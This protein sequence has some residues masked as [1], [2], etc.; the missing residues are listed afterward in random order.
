MVRMALIGCGAAGKS[1]LQEM[2]KLSEI[3]VVAVSDIRKEALD[4]VRQKF[5]I[6][7]TYIDYKEMMQ[8]EELDA[9]SIVTPT[10]THP[11]VIM[12]AA[13][14]GL[15]VMCEKPLSLSVREGEAA[16]EAMRRADRVLAVTYTYRFVPDTRRMK[17][18]IDS[19]L[20]GDIL[21]IRYLRY[22]GR[23]EKPPEGSEQ[24]RRYDW[25]FSPEGLGLVYDCGIHGFDLL[26]W[27]AGSEVASVWAS[28]EYHMGYDYPD[29]ATAIFRYEN[30][31]K[32]LF[33]YGEVA[34]YVTDTG[35]LLFKIIVTGRQGTAV[36]HYAGQRVE[37]GWRTTISTYTKAGR[38]QEMF[39]TYTKA[40][41]LQYQ[42]FAES[43]RSGHLQGY[44]G[45]AE[46][47]VEATR[48]G[49]E[50]LRQCDERST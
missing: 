10:S 36:W 30:G 35:G 24:R 1:H 28:G 26:R 2:L 37:S 6:D 22:E 9:V 13:A 8:K 25:F 17:E 32:G 15:H 33:D 48:I 18:I 46:D 34:P 39:L 50:V 14:H 11:E 45:T 49:L 43:V 12:T 31:I 3:K 27:Y 38:Q 20:L 4:E 42:Q 40:R 7:K 29:S 47:A 19:G 21:E 44:W 41:D 23:P 16:V 5:G